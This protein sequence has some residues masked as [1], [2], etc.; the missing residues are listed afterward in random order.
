[1][2]LRHYVHRRRWH[3]VGDPFVHG[4]GAAPDVIWHHQVA[5][6]KILAPLVEQ[7]KVARHRQYQGVF[8]SAI[9][10]RPGHQRFRSF[11]F[12]AGC[13]KLWT[14]SRQKRPWS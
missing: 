14:G 3:A 8:G 5:D 4:I 11:G 9:A 6:R 13:L 12:R 2:E 1:M 7:R 10:Q